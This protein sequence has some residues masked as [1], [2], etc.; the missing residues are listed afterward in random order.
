MRQLLDTPSKSQQPLD[1]KDLMPTD[2]YTEENLLPVWG[3]VAHVVEKANDQRTNSAPESQWSTFIIAP[4]LDLLHHVHRHNHKEPQLQ[5]LDVTTTPIEPVDLCPYLNHPEV[6]KYLNKRIDFAVGLRISHQQKTAL[7][8]GRYRDHRPG[9]LHSINQTAGWANHVPIFLNIE[10]KKKHVPEDPMVQIGVWVAAEFRKRVIEGYDLDMPV[11]AIEIEEDM[12]NLYIGYVTDSLAE[13]LVFMG[14][15]SMG[16]T[17]SPQGVFK[18][19]HV[20]H[21]LM[22]WGTSDYRS[23]FE[24]E[25]LTKHQTSSNAPG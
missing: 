14:P 13:N 23:W 16:D 6:S 17:K 4:I 19:L 10:V 8:H 5:V 7:Q 3:A 11:F 12:W 20:L 24:R 22:D 15:E 18:I 2:R 9:T 25:V 1:D 21:S